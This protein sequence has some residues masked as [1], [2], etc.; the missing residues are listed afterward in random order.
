[1]LRVARSLAAPAAGPRAA[2]Q[3][4]LQSVRTSTTAGELAV[5]VEGT[6]L[7]GRDRWEARLGEARLYLNRKDEF[8]A[9]L[10]ALHEKIVGQ[11]LLAWAT[12]AQLE[13]VAFAV[14]DVISNRHATK[15][16]TE[17]PEVEVLLEAVGEYVTPELLRQL[18]APSA[19]IAQLYH[20]AA[21]RQCSVPGWLAQLARP[22]F[23]PPD[24]QTGGGG[25]LPAPVSLASLRLVDLGRLAELPKDARPQVA[26][27]GF[28]VRLQSAALARLDP[29][30]GSGSGSGSGSGVRVPAEAQK[31]GAEL[32]DLLATVVLRGP[33]SPRPREA[34]GLA[35]AVC[36]LLGDASVSPNLVAQVAG[37]SEALS[38]R[39]AFM[40]FK[41]GA[42]PSLAVPC[43]TALLAESS[44]LN[45]QWTLATSSTMLWSITRPRF[46]LASHAADALLHM[47]T[48]AQKCLVAAGSTPEKAESF[49]VTAQPLLQLRR[50]FRDLD[51]H[52]GSLR[53]VD[54]RVD[55][56][57]SHLLRRPDVLRSISTGRTA[58]D[59]LTLF[60]RPVSCFPRCVDALRRELRGG[61]LSVEPLKALACLL[62]HTDKPSL[63]A[64]PGLS[65]VVGALQAA[66]VRAGA[67][68]VRP[69]KADVAAVAHAFSSLG[70]AVMKPQMLVVLR[71]MV[72]AARSPPPQQQRQQQQQQQ[73]SKLAA[74]P[75]TPPAGVGA[76]RVATKKIR[77]PVQDGILAEIASWKDDNDDEES[78]D[79]SG[80][81]AG[82]QAR[83]HDFGEGKTFTPLRWMAV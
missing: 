47:S 55:A 29:T 51:R 37:K 76:Q 28:A 18:A 65:F 10:A 81:A 1:M 17:F 24:R 38:A 9:V 58:V 61:V 27:D 40:L 39:V 36:L 53:V 44:R 46:R 35:N 2:L 82:D 31:R 66:V 30:G 23:S 64:T 11:D 69:R 83:G 52:G 26:G 3:S 4:F 49:A 43:L 8:A 63:E 56:A 19:L 78:D 54:P 59:V 57:F 22:L 41:G 15:A 6:V 5:A 12:P 67:K 79:A 25:G 75:K 48:A 33:F 73:S 80:A 50:V 45:R 13:A 20:T 60:S 71:E 32:I 70:P 62:Q 72:D 34:V 14:Q 77:V 42:E 21:L 68:G 16:A 7:S 74:S